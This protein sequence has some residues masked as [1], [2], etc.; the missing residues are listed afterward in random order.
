[1]VYSLYR[2]GLANSIFTHFVFSHPHI[3]QCS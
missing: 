2:F 1:V 3:V